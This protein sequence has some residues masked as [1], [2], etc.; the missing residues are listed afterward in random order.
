MKKQKSD[1]E[2]E[3]QRTEVLVAGFEDVQSPGQHQDKCPCELTVASTSV[4]AEAEDEEEDLWIVKALPSFIKVERQDET[5]PI[6]CPC[7]GQEQSGYMVSCEGC[8][9]RLYG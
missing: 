8:G 7:G 4:K 6:Q 2:E 1:A 3:S 5:C 9:V